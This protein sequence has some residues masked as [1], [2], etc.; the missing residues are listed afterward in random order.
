MGLFGILLGLALLIWLA[1][2]GWSIL[3]LAPG[4]ALIAAAFAGGPLLAYW[5][6]T[7]MD[8]ASRFVAQFFPLFLLGALFGKLMEDSGSVSA[9]AEFMTERLGPSRAILTV[10][11]AGALVTYGGVSLF[12]AVFVLAPMAQGLF[13]TAQI[14][15]RLIPAT[16]FLGTSTFT[17]S[18]LPGT[19]AIQNAIPIPFFGTTPL[20]APGLGIIASAIMAGFGMWWLGRAATAARRNGEGFGMTI[21]GSAD[22]AA[23]DE[24]VR[25]RATT[26]REFDP[27]EVS[28]GHPSSEGPPIG[29][30][31]LPLLVVISVNVLMTLVVLPR[32]DVSFLA[33]ERFGAT[34]LHAVGG[35]WSVVTALLAAILTVAAVNWR[36]LRGLRET[37]EL[38][39][40]RLGLADLERRQPGRLW[41]GRRGG[42]GIRDRAQLGAVDRRRPARLAGGGD[43]FA[44]G[45]D[46]LGLR[47][48]DDRARCPRGYVY[49]V[50]HAARH[51]PGAVASHRRDERRNARQPAAE[52]RRR[53]RALGLRHNAQREL[54]RHCHGRHRRPDHRARR[55][56]RARLSI[57]FVL[58]FGPGL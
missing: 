33:E 48:L 2:R 49:A 9:I 45:F 24:A 46:W 39:R 38:G 35:V 32:L 57:R 3:L 53:D 42:A 37:L 25:Q 15:N 30:A 43:Q 1:Y 20:A 54:F 41:R 16:V 31:A 36:R 26:A 40:Q 23:Q 5:T 27:V 17:M 44:L 55:G 19:P 4:A 29:L 7:F 58:K 6:Q 13:R 10:V 21:P 18:A 8:S 47:R 14:P 52:R 12:V 34:S 22:A 11:L 56:H 28:R 50:G 51:R